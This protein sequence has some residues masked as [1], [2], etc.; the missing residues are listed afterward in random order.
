MATDINQIIKNLTSFYSFKGKTVAHVGAG[1]R[2]LIDE[3]NLPVKIIAIDQDENG[4][5]QFKEHIQRTNLKDKFTFICNDFCDV[6][7]SCDTVLF[8][9]C[10]HE[11]KDPAHALTHAREIAGETIVIDHYPGSEWAWYT[12]ETEK[13]AGS[14][15]AVNKQHIKR[16]AIFEAVQVFKNYDEIYEKV[17]V[18]GDEA[19]SRIRQYREKQD[20]IIHMPY[21]I[22]LL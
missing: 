10:L 21:G 8:E 2:A 4:L 6:Q 19:I 16:Q 14:W 5:N 20:F 13:I 15:G 22:V 1:T 11:M 18:L 3:S 12:C 7:L 17:N 9:F